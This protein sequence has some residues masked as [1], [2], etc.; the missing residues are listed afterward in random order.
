MGALTITNFFFSIFLLIADQTTHWKYE[1]FISISSVAIGLQMVFLVDMIIN[2]T[3]LGFRHV[4]KEKKV[5]Y[6]E[7]VTQIVSVFYIIKFVQN[8]N[9]NRYMELTELSIM[10]MVRNI[11]AYHFLIEI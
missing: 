11:R 2:F 3:V 6:V 7:L 10:T 4:W 1:H 5:I 9:F 8:P